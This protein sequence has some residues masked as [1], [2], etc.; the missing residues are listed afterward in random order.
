MTD[1]YEDFKSKVHPVLAQNCAAGN[2]H[3]AESNSLRLVCDIGTTDADV[4]AR[5]NYFAAV[6]YLA[7]KPGELATSE[8]LR[9]PL[10]PA[11]GGAYHEG[12]PI[13]PNQSDPGYKAILEWAN[14]HGPNTNIPRNRGFDFFAKRVQPMLVKKGCM[15]I[16][17][18]SPAMFHDYRLRGGSGGNF[19]VPTSSTNYKLTSDQLALETPDPAASRLIAKNLLRPDQ[20]AG[21]RGILH[22]GGA[23]FDDFTDALASPAALR[24]F[25]RRGNGTAQRSARLLHH[26]PLDPDRAGRDGPV[27]SFGHGLRQATSRCP[28][29]SRRRIL[30]ATGARPTS[31]SALSP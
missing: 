25:Y 14:V 26:R 8:I 28:S 3:G 12:G 18:H 22:R 6:Q 2:C 20:Q 1:D 17:C 15:A 31:V 4:L 16:G 5:W 11:A 24:R 7:T 19:S 23:L 13:F 30:R 21:G 10:D 29:R 27:A 9:R